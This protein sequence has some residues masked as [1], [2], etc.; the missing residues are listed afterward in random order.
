MKTPLLGR[1]VPALFA[2][3][4]ALAVT[5]TTGTAQKR[6]RNLVSRA[7]IDSSPHIDRDLLTALRNLRPHFLAPP[8]GVRSLGGGSRGPFV[9]SIN[10]GRT[11]GMDMLREIMANTVEEVRYLDPTQSEN[12]FGITYNSGGIVIKLRDM[13]RD[14]SAPKPAVADTTRKVPR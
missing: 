11:T 4:L 10:G 12:E 1:A 8:R 14:H 7:E 13:T 3:A 9:V 6:E 5:P 2:V